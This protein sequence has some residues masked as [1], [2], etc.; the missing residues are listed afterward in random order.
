MT[1]VLEGG[2]GLASHPG[3]FNPW[4]DPVPIVQEAVWAPGPVWTGAENLAHT[5]I[6]SPY[7][8]AR[9]HSLY[10][11]R[12]PDYYERWT[13][14]KGNLSSVTVVT[15]LRAGRD[16]LFVFNSKLEKEACVSTKL[17]S[18]VVLLS[19][20]LCSERPLWISSVVLSVELCAERPL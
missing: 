19:V 7:R 10:R 12:Y 2:E 16:V 6:R 14:C 15:R 13:K 5:G 4:K 18:V 20:D 1:T 8:P 9:S 11:L 17:S 3:R